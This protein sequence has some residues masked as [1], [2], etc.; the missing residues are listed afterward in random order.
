FYYRGANIRF[1]GI[2]VVQL[3]MRL[4]PDEI[5]ALSLRFRE[6]AQRR[7]VPNG[8]ANSPKTE[9]S[10]DGFAIEYTYRFHIEGLSDFPEDYAVYVLDDSRSAPE[11]E[12]GYPTMYGASIHEANSEIV[13]WMEAIVPGN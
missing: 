5:Q 13:Y 6:Q 10:P 4:P 9:T 12:W 11:Y 8:E 7:Y 2:I 1:G 3:S